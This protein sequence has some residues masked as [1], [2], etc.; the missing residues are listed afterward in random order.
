MAINDF[1]LGRT[2]LVTGG[3]GFMGSLLIKK[4]LNEQGV[5]RIISVSRRWDDSERMMGAFRDSRLICK[6]GDV[7]DR[8]FINRI[9]HK[10]RPECV[11]HAAAYKSVPSSEENV[12]EVKSVNLDG[13]INVVEAANFCEDT[14]YLCFIS[15]DK[16]CS[17][18]NTYGRSKALAESIVSNTTRDKVFFSVRYG[19]VV[20]ST[21]AV[22]DK[23][24]ASDKYFVTDPEMTRFWFR[25]SSAAQFVLDSFERAKPGD[26]FVPE[27][28]SSTMGDLVEAF[29]Y[30]IPKEIV[31]VGARPA[32]KKHEEMISEAEVSRT[33]YIPS[34]YVGNKGVFAILPPD[35]TINFRIEDRFTSENA[36]RYT[37]NELVE[38]I[39]EYLE[40]SPPY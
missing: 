37:H 12:L 33:N 31:E 20:G 7:R 6:N 35:R 2:V 19:N 5:E 15:T 17:A 26:V 28:K 21:G 29:S 1:W 38:L 14:R 4:L 24:M 32:E 39:K 9:F 30:L 40:F 25:P 27:L 16:A 10:F 3:T 11:I 8:S 18:V 13:T 36:E 23:F 22:F 34:I